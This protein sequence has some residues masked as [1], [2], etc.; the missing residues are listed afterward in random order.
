MLALTLGASFALLVAGSALADT[1]SGRIVGKD[2]TARTLTIETDGG[3]RF[4]Y[5]V[6]S[7]TQLTRNGNRIDLGGL[8]VGDRVEVTSDMQA[9]ADDPAARM[10]SRVEV[11]AAPAGTAAAPG[12]ADDMNTRTAQADLD[13]DDRVAERRLPST[14]SPLPL[15]GLAGLV[16]AAGGLALRRT[17]R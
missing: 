2:A 16:S 9:N 14:A 4:A 5:R 1:Q 7:T 3:D 17:R 10:A 12:D 8:Q 13:R 11:Q 6:D 15:I